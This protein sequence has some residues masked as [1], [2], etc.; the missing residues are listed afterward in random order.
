MKQW[1]FCIS[2]HYLETMEQKIEAIM[3]LPRIGWSDSWSCIL[4]ACA[5]WGI[6]VE[7][8]GGAFWD[9]SFQWLFESKV[10]NGCTWILTLDYD[11]MFTAE[12]VATLIQHFAQ[13]PDIDALAALQFRRG[14]D[15]TPLFGMKGSKEGD[16]VEVTN[17]PIFVDTAHFG[18]TLLR[19]EKLVQLPKPWFLGV[20]D[21]EGR[22]DTDDRTDADIY[23]WRQ[24]RAAGF[25]IAVDPEVSIGHLQVMVSELDPETGKCRHVHVNEWRQS[26]ART[27]AV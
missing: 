10:R 24:W 3:T 12:H 18:L 22:W 15:E 26:V 7:T 16:Q 8:K 9:Q 13:R 6:P 21:S 25:T 14:D 23:F 1:A 20:P 19:V 11:S 17:A 27:T 5:V 4:N 2:R